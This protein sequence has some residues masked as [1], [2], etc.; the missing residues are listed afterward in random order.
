[1]KPVLILS[2][3][4]IHVTQLSFAQDDAVLNAKMQFSSLFLGTNDNFEKLKGTLYSEDDNWNYFG[5]E[6]GL[7]EKA[8]TILKSKKDSTAWYCYIQF[9]LETDMEAVLPIQ[10]GT[11]EM[12]NMMITAGKIRGTENTE[13]GITRTDLYVKSNDAWLG[14]LVTD[15]KKKT[16]H[17]LLKNTP[18]P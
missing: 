4:L 6:Y 16:F 9:S 13:D 14:E 8:V 7:G 12:L 1:M 3:L 17:I 10:T 11:F 5:S 15:S 18:W 2:I